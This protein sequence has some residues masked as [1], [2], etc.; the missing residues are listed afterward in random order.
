[1]TTTPPDALAALLES[2]GTRAR[3]DLADWT[4]TVSCWPPLPEDGAT[5]DLRVD[6]RD[7]AALPG[8]RGRLHRP[9]RRG[10]AVLDVA[11]VSTSGRWL[12]LRALDAAVVQRRRHTRAMTGRARMRPAAGADWSATPGRHPL[13]RL[14]DLSESGLRVLVPH[15]P[16]QLGTSVDVQLVLGQDP[17]LSDLVVVRG[18]VHR[19]D[20]SPDGVVVAVHLDERLPGRSPERIRAAVLRA[21]GAARRARQERA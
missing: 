10:L 19:H 14:L 16:P 18:T 11:V 20:P 7:V 3:L 1:M 8:T 4:R 21:Q 13:L 6:V 2:P 15:D 12:L 5:V 9:D 17:D